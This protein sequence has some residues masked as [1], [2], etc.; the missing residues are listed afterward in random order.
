MR[1]HICCHTHSNT[2][3]AIHKQQRY[4]GWQYGWLLNC[5]IEVGSPINSLL[6]DVGHHLVG[7]LLHTGLCVTHSRSR[8]TVH[9]TEVTLTLYKRIT[10]SPILSH[11]NHSLVN[12]AIAVRVELTEHVSHNTGRLTSRLVGIEI[13]LSTHIIQNTT[14]YRLQTITHIRQRTRYDNRHRVIDIG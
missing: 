11:T 2:T 1:C 9:R 5:I 13:Q 4:L 12:R 6:I 8:V 14:M 3:C 10:H 7:N